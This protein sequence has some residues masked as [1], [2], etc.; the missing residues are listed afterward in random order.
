LGLLRALGSVNAV[1]VPL[2]SSALVAMGVNPAMLDGGCREG[3]KLPSSATAGQQ[4]AKTV[5]TQSFSHPR[6]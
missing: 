6:G 2:E 1:V 3:E 5:L 4:R